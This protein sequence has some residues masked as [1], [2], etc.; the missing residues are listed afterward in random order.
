[1]WIEIKLFQKEIFIGWSPPSLA[2][3]IEIGVISFIGSSKASPPSLA[4]WIEMLSITTVLWLPDVT[5]FAGGV[6]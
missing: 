1:M 4:V 5:A 2:V 6:D 3:W